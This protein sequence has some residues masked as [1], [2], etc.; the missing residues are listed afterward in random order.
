[1]LLNLYSITESEFQAIE[2]NAELLEKMAFSETPSTT[3]VLDLDKNWEALNFLLTGCSL[4]D[5]AEME[6]Y[7]LLS[8]SIF[9]SKYI[10]EEVDLGYGP[11]S[12]I[13]IEV[14]KSL[15][16][17]LSKIISEEL[18]TNYDSDKMGEKG[19]YPNV[20]NDKKYESENLQ[21][22]IESFE[23]LKAFYKDAAAN[24]H[25]VISALY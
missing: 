9:G 7:P 24:N 22:L 2:A 10:H 6:A 3:K 19:I 14:I 16:V 5:I 20:W 15:D 18:A 1:M 21:Q 25:V 17:A 13:T 8:Q 12:Y 11:G 4:V 23:E